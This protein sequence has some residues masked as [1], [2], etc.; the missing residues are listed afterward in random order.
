MP[1]PHPPSPSFPN[2]GVVKKKGNEGKKERVLKQKLLKDCQLGQNVTVLT[3]LERLVEFK[4]FSNR[5]TIVAD[6]T[7]QYSMA[8]SL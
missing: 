3:I 5:P 8:P 1:P 6:I 2:F 7:F 4:N